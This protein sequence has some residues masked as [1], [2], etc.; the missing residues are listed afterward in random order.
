MK[1]ALLII[2]VQRGMFLEENPVFKAEELLGNLKQLLE[3]ARKSQ[4]Q[5]VFIQH[6]A[7]AGKTLE[8]GTEAWEIH[9]DITPASTELIIEKTTPDSFY[10]THLYEELMK[11]SIEHVV[12]AGIQSE[13]CVDTTCR[14]AFSMGFDVTLATDAH[15]TWNS[16]G[17]SAQQIIDHH[18]QVLR[19][20]ADTKETKDIKFGVLAAEI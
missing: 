15:S 7:P 4:V 17:L 18:N 2:D 16:A 19:W 6:N 3:S 5:V 12:L 11:R 8:P 20:F 1:T 14:R 9:P 10:Q 13:V